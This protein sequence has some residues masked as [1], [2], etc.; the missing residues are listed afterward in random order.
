M[1]PC[2]VAAL[3][4]LT[5]TCDARKSWLNVADSTPGTSLNRSPQDTES[6]TAHPLTAYNWDVCATHAFC[7]YCPTEDNLFC[8]FFVKF[9]VANCISLLSAFYTDVLDFWCT[10]GVAESI[11]AGTFWDIY[12]DYPNLPK[13][14]RME[15]CGSF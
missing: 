15:E 11:A 12:A 14:E 5:A 9:Y 1:Y 4:N 7:L 8:N 10:D 13:R 3:S 2:A 6:D